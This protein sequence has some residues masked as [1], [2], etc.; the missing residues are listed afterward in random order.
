MKTRGSY[1]K[2]SEQFFVFSDRT[3]VKP[4][5][6]RSVLRLI[7]SRL[8]LDSSLYNVHSLR[9]CEWTCDLEKFGYSVDKIKAMGH[10]R[11]NAVYRYLKN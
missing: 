10:W 7:I 5:N 3:P 6:V 9:I 2:E 8:G 1:L 11:S 4:N